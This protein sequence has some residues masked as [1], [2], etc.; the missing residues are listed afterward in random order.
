MKIRS[1]APR[2]VF[3][4]LG[5][6]SLIFTISTLPMPLVLAQQDAS[7]QQAAT[8]P[9]PP[10]QR[11]ADAQ[12]APL[13]LSPIEKAEKDRTAL[14][15]SLKDIT[16]LALQ[17]NLNI[18]IQDTNEQLYQQ[19]IIQAYGPYDPTITVGLGVRSTK[20]PNTRQDTK[21]TAGNFN[22]TDFANWNSSITQN[23]KTGGGISASYN[24]SRNDNNQLFSLFTPQYNSSLSLNFTQPLRRDFRID[25][26][27]GTIKLANLDIKINDSKFK[28][29]VAQTIST[30]QGQYWDLVGAIRNY[31]IKREAV[32]LAQITL[33]D[34]K[35]KVEIGTAAPITVTE[36]LATMAQRQVDL[37]SAEEI[38]YN[39]E[40]A[41][42]ALISNDRNA[43][44]WHKVIIPTETP[45]FKEY[46]V[47]LDVAIDTALKNRP[48]LE[49]VDLSLQGYDISQRMSENMQKW[50]VDLT[51]GFGTTGVA[52]PQS[53]TTDP[54]TG[55]QKIL[56]DPNLVGGIGNANKLLFSGG[57]INWAV[58]FSIQIPLRNRTVD[59]QLAQIKI[60]RRQQLMT[61]KNAEQQIQVDIR[62]AVQKIETNRQQVE[63]AKIARQLTQEQLDGE[64]KRF[65]AGLSQNFQVLTRQNDLTAAQGVEL[66]A[67]IAYKKSI[68]TLQQAMY[69]L[70]EA[71]DFEIAKT[72]SD[73]VPN[74]K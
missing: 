29:S 20:S 3:S 25:Q 17:N 62:N 27:R 9:Q 8:A 49:Q 16:K 56:I 72:S 48:E 33:R 12:L 74:L 43:E 28:Q 64:E 23:F 30:I 60:Q 6:L 71:N 55:L 13:P 5:V 66:Q 7:A 59:A 36:A 40:N 15:L 10:A 51:G 69:T 61:R 37:I 1:A 21:S 58:G 41:L 39:S 68:I 18:A 44:I 14:R 46:K 19:R 26:Y 11:A 54:I 73:N 67:L 63:T 52:G 31:E 57:Y 50:R 53:Y 45:D 42:R 22:K 34:N 65:Q 4:V 2:R 32:K 47:D 24:S 70:L 35:K 38:I